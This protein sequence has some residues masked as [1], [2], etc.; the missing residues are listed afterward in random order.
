MDAAIVQ[1]LARRQPVK[2]SSIGID[3]SVEAAFGVLTMTGNEE[4]EDRGKPGYG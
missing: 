2:T 4:L 1:S 3:K